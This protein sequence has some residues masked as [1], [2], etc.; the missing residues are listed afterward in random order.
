MAR[1]SCSQL[2]FFVILLLLFHKSTFK[3]NVEHLKLQSNP[4]TRT[5]LSVLL[6]AHCLSTG[7]ISSHNT[8]LGWG[9]SPDLLH[10][11]GHLKECGASKLLQ[12][13]RLRDTVH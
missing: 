8:H 1:A 6:S 11:E 13:Q 3:V 7:E 9:K 2:V 5:H 4:Q 12:G 10:A